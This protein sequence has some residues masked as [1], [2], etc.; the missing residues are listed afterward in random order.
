MK[1]RAASDL[2]PD[3]R[4]AEPQ[5][6]CASD[7]SFLNL[8]KLIP[9]IMRQQDIQSATYEGGHSPRTRL[10]TGIYNAVPGSRA[11]RR[12][13]SGLQATARAEGV[14]WGVYDRS[15]YFGGLVS[16]FPQCACPSIT[17][18]RDQRHLE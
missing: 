6:F 5:T 4:A 18:E 17:V 7:I 11:G 2:P 14:T 16:A 3:L 13:F 15:V 8:R 10:F 9:T 1:G 12:D